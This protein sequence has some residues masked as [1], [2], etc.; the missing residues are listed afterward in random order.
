M[1][2]AAAKNAEH[3]TIVTDKQDYSELVKELKLTHDPKNIFG[4]KNG[5][6]AK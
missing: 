4:A 3:V 2:R 5:I 1:V 6:L